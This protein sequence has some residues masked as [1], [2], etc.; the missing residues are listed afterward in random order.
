MPFTPKAWANGS[1]ANGRLDAAAMIDIE[2]RLGAYI[3]TA[4]AVRARNQL[5]MPTGAIS[6]TYP[7]DNRG[8]ACAVTSTGVL[9]LAG[10]LLVPANQTV[11]NVTFV[12]STTP[13]GTPTNWWFCIVDQALNV[14]RK[15]ADQTTTAW[16]AST[17][18]TLALAT[19]YTPT[20]DT[21]LYAGVMV[22]ATTVPTF[23]GSVM[24]AGGTGH[25]A[26]TPKFAGQSTGSLTTPASLGATAA[27]LTPIGDLP[28]AYLS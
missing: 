8:D 5:W 25:T 28:Y 27:A 23:V 17:A 20:S 7:R 16:A 6:E 10:G 4:V 13:A 15:T 2:T 11:T 24:S 26:L 1:V 21:P 3:D 22:K 12:S 19:T 9:Y 14:L 18:K